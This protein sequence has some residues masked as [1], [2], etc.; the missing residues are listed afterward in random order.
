MPLHGPTGRFAPRWKKQGKTI[1]PLDLLIAAR[2]RSIGATALTG[3][4]DEFMRV[5]RLKVLRWK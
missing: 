2:A 4:Y 3:N 1:G 5:P